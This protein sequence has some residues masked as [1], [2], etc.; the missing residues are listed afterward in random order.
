MVQDL[1]YFKS[2]HFFDDSL[3][4]IDRESFAT[5][6]LYITVHIHSMVHSTYFFSSLYIIWAASWEKGV[7]GHRDQN[8]ITA[9]QRLRSVKRHVAWPCN[10]YVI[11]ARRMRILS[12]LALFV[13]EADIPQCI[14]LII[15]RKSVKD[16]SSC[17]FLKL[18]YRVAEAQILRLTWCHENGTGMVFLSVV[19]C[20]VFC[21]HKGFWKA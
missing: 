12:P 11:I 10:I 17:A 7:L 19:C 15:W 16:C 18:D 9:H 8:R 20:C 4:A 6:L 3:R 2:L 5:G 13:Q 14:L 1:T 21:G